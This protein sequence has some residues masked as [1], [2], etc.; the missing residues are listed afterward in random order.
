[1]TIVVVIAGFGIARPDFLSVENILLD[2]GQQSAVIAIVAFAMTPVIVGARHGHLPGSTVALTGVLAALLL[3]DG[4]STPLALAAVVLAGA[5]VGRGERHPDRRVGIS[6][7]MATLATLASA[8]GA[9]LLLS[10]D[11]GVR[12]ENAT[13]AWLGDGGSAR[14]RSRWSLPRSSSLAG[15][16]C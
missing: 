9:A 16:G 3:Q 5:G 8:R 4:V 6:P 1:M 11:S 7:F 14:C 13:I 12:V 10:G 2:I 15:W